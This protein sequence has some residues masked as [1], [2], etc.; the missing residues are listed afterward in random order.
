MALSITGSNNEN[1]AAQAKTQSPLA[2]VGSNAPAAASSGKVQPGTAN[3]LLA[4]QGS[5]GEGISL[6]STPLSVVNLNPTQTQA[7]TAQPSVDLQNQK[8]HL[9]PVL[10]GLAVGLLVLAVI[11]FWVTARSAKNTTH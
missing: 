1:P 2:S 8:H 3:S 5:N 4:Q 10:L 7:T 6:H 11:F 9:N